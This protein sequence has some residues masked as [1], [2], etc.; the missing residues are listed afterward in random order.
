MV[1]CGEVIDGSL[2]SCRLLEEAQLQDLEK[3]LVLA[4]PE[5]LH[6]RKEKEL[7]YVPGHLVSADLCS[8]VTAVC[9]V[10]LHGQSPALGEQVRCHQWGGVLP[11]PPQLPQ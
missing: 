1:S 8:R 3:A 4:N 5:A 6:W 2:H 9:G 10:L 11:Y 7:Q